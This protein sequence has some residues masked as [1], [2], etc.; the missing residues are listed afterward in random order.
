MLLLPV[1]Y[2]VGKDKIVQCACNHKTRSHKI[3]QI[4]IIS[5]SI[6]EYYLTF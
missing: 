3:I 6:L 5:V 1:S 2:M 4:Y